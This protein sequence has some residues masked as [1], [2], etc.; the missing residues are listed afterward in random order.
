[1]YITEDCVG[2]RR[3]HTRQRGLLLRAVTTM[4][5]LLGLGSVSNCAD[6]TSP[7]PWRDTSDVLV[8]AN[9]PP[10]IDAIS[11]PGGATTRLPLSHTTDVAALDASGTVLLTSGPGGGDLTATSVTTGRTLW[12]ERLSTT[13]APRLDRWNGIII[14]GQAGLAETGD[15]TALFIG[16]AF[17]DSVTGTEGVAI[18]DS[19]TRD[20]RAFVAPFFLEARGVAAV[21]AK[22]GAPAAM[23][24]VGR[25]ERYPT[26]VDDWLYIVDAIRFTIIDSTHV[27]LT[28]G[29]QH[30]RPLY[31]PQYNSAVSTLYLVQGGAIPCLVAVGW[32]SLTVEASVCDPAF[33][34]FALSP[35]GTLVA[36]FRKAD[37]TTELVQYDA[38]LHERN[39][40]N[41]GRDPDSGLPA[42]GQDVAVS[43]TAAQAF[44]IA[45]TGSIVLDEPGPQR[46]RLYVID[47]VSWQ[48]AHIVPLGL[49][50]PKQV[51]GVR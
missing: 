12:S 14:G 36:L 32:P 2:M 29:S 49:F 15:G 18:L 5:A 17:A 10:T 4:V 50:S 47:V 3:R 43:R 31:M 21:P 30:P 51:F 37:W 26:I 9:E 48:I 27:D 34:V 23:A 6:S 24:M 25:R 33:R 44:V 8:V 41:L 13:F 1:M 11:L 42:L 39:R 35:D 38:L 7:V 20:L 46:G 40:L 28:P 45:G 19:R 22:D 16:P